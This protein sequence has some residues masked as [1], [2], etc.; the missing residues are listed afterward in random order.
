MGFRNIYL[1]SSI[2]WVASDVQLIDAAS[3]LAMQDIRLNNVIAQYFS[4]GRPTCDALESLILDDPKPTELD[5]PDVQAEIIELFNAGKLGQGDLDHT[6]FNLLLPPGTVLKLGDSSSTDG[7]GGYHGSVHVGDTTLYYSA[8]V[9]SQPL[10]G[11]TENGIVAFDASW[12][13]VVATLY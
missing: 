4:G 2:D 8:N 7:L 3:K 12:K 11:G 5:E 10:P 6:I 1:G 13:N 9:F